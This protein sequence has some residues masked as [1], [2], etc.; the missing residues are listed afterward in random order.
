M[1]NCIHFTNKKF[2]QGL[3][4]NHIYIY[5]LIS[6]IPNFPFFLYGLSTHFIFFDQKITQ[7]TISYKSFIK[8]FESLE[9]IGVNILKS[10][11]H[12]PTKERN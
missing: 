6:L 5:V 3:Y 11:N 4:I 9:G 1:T 2:V 12:A 8:E 7:A 10:L